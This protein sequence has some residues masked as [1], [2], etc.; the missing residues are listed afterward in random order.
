M[1]IGLPLRSYPPALHKGVIPAVLLWLHQGGK[2]LEPLRRVPIFNRKGMRNIYDDLQG[3]RRELA[4]K[5]WNGKVGARFL[6]DRK[7]IEQFA[8]GK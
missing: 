7:H 2:V 1:Q 6:I 8:I 3:S 4:L 5:S